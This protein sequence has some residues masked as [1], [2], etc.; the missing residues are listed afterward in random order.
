MEEF[1]LS[2]TGS[3]L[4]DILMSNFGV[5]GY[6]HLLRWMK[7]EKILKFLSLCVHLCFARDRISV[8]YCFDFQTDFL[9]HFNNSEEENC[10]DFDDFRLFWQV[11]L[12]LVIKSRLNVICIVPE[13]HENTFRNLIQCQPITN[14][15][16]QVL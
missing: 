15:E 8:V 16:T 6:E 2:L 10:T 11:L 13:S 4:V 5:P 9:D 1:E 7:L 3:L 14:Q 12:S